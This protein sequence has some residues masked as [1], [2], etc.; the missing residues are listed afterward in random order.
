MHVAYLYPEHLGRPEARLLQVA[1]TLRA[2][3]RQG[4]QVSFLVGRFAGLE[5]RL[6]ELGLAGQAGLMVEPLAMWQPG[7]GSPAFF[8]WHLPYHL[9]AL[10]RLGRLAGQGLTWVLARHLKLTGFLLPRLPGLGLKLCFEAH[11]LFS[12]TAREEGADPAKVAA[13][14]ALEARVFTGADRLAAISRPLA[15]ALEPLPGVRGPVLVAPSGVEEAFFSLGGQPRQPGLVAYA[16]GL[17]AWKGVDLLIQAVARVPQARLEVLGGR[18]DSD[19]WRRLE[20]LAQELGL[21]ERL[22]MRPQAGQEAVAEL[23]GRATVAVW[24]GSGRQRI[25]AEFTSPLK[26]FEYLAAGCAV[27]APDLP[28]ARAVL[29]Q[30]HNARL[31]TPDDPDSLAQALSGLLAAPLEVERLARA[32]RRLARA[33][34]WDARARVLLAAMAE[35]RP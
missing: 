7:P 3:A 6:E 21:A 20:S 31:F 8:S 18:P 25:A 14:A 9:A 27:L 13:L 23:L 5:R 11:E 34:T 10:A 33:Y 22:V 29:A 30:G 15:A 2:L 1:A 19:D 17:G 12:Q 35:A 28:A 4:A 16:G 32:G 26:L 24:P